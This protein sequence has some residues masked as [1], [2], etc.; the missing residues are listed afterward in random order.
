MGPINNR[1][2]GD[3]SLPFVS[4][5][6]STFARIH[7][8]EEAAESF[9]RQDYPGRK[10]LVI[11]NDMP[12]Q[13]LVFDHPEVRIINVRKRIVPLGRKFNE[14]VRLCRGSVL[15]VWD[16]DD[17]YLPWRL[18]YSIENMHEGIF[19]TRSGLFEKEKNQPLESME[20]IFHCNLAYERRYFTQSGGYV[21]VDTRGTDIK[22]MDQ[23]GVVSQSVRPESRFYIYRWS[24]TGAYHV[25]QWNVDSGRV[26]DLTD[27][28]VKNEKEKGSF[29]K[30]RIRLVPHWSRDWISLVKE[31]RTD[32]IEEE[33]LEAVEEVRLDQKTLQISLPGEET[34]SL[35]K[36]NETSALVFLAIDGKRK[37]REILDLI[38]DVFPEEETSEDVL[39]VLADLKAKEIVRPVKVLK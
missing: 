16:D 28:C 13:E 35:F 26:S 2:S 6:C 22:F 19:H 34:G 5:Y 15:F 24:G 17:I 32:L 27:A 20:N 36:C 12:D 33:V 10:E 18:S 38:S 23:I 11:L 14:C 4:C 25:S 30:G 39:S 37:N 8:L 29:R 31:A 3:P 7:T 21:E 1:L 9:L